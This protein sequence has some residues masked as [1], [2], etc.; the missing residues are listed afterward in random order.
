[1]S[2]RQSPRFSY[3]IEKAWCNVTVQETIRDE[4][5]SDKSKTAQ[6]DPQYENFEKLAKEYLATDGLSCNDLDSPTAAPAAKKK[7]TGVRR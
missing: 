6:S 5:A 4:R 7:R 3:D 1:L 2:T